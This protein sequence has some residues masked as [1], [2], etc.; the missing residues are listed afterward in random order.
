M[1]ISAVRTE[2]AVSSR[3]NCAYVLAFSGLG[4]WARRSR[5]FFCV[6][7]PTFF[8]PCARALLVGVTDVVALLCSFT[9][10]PRA[11]GA[12]P[13]GVFASAAAFGAV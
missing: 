8:S 6:C 5:S 3:E 10:F 4:A 9:L 12:A 7:E 13:G 2:L 11:G 1:D